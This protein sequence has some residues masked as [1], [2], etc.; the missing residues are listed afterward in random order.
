MNLLRKRRPQSE[1]PDLYEACAPFYDDDYAALRSSGDALFYRKLAKDSGGPVL[2]MG[3][4]SGRVLLPIARAG[5]EVVG[6]DGSPH[7]LAQLRRRLE[8]EKPAVR[9]RVE[10]VEADMRTADLGRTFPLLTAPFRGVQ[11]LLTRDDQR[12][13]LR[14]AARHLA[15]GGELVFDVFQP[16][17]RYFASPPQGVVDVDRT[18]PASGRPVRRLVS[19]WQRPEEQTFHMRVEWKIG[20]PDGDDYEEHAGDTVM[21][22][23]TR[24]E[25]ENLLELEGYRVLDVWGD[26][27][28]TPHGPGAAEIVLRAVRP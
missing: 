17:Y 1:V 13:W 5:V 16:D 26:F 15:P 14:T 19:L 21:R 7:M 6:L 2:E 11:H 24:A 18:D 8:S 22:W 25:L 3:C 23:F 9:Q 28:R 4:G 10:V 20:D 12:A 27:R